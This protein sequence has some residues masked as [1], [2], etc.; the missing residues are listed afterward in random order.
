MIP[1]LF[2]ILKLCQLSSFS[3]CTKTLIIMINSL[4]A[5][6]KCLLGGPLVTRRMS[7]SSLG[8]KN[9]VNLPLPFDSAIFVNLWAHNF[10]KLALSSLVTCHHLQMSPWG[11]FGD[12]TYQCPLLVYDTATLLIATFFNCFLLSSL[13]IFVWIST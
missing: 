8:N 4:L 9:F 11:A 5:T 2:M 1:F 10:F 3:I 6:S 13:S 7:P 12:V